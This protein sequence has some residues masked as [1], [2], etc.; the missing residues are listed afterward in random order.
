MSS[1]DVTGD[2]GAVTK[3]ATRVSRK[4]NAEIDMLADT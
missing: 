2:M 4:K 3:D 1:L